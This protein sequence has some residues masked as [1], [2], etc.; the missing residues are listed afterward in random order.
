MYYGY[1]SKIIHQLVHF[2]CIYYSVSFI[3]INI[4]SSAFTNLDYH[5]IIFLKLNSW[6]WAPWLPYGIKIRNH[7]FIMNQTLNW[8]DLT[9]FILFHLQK[10]FHGLRTLRSHR[11]CSFIYTKYE[12]L[13]TSNRILWLTLILRGNWLS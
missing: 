11:A 10:F 3:Y 5:R 8:S 13:D 4:M 12:E 7:V 9:I 2:T 1:F 6:F